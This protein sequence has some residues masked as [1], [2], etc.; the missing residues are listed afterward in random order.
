MGKKARAAVLESPGQIVIKQFDIP[1][2]GPEEGLLRIEMAGVC[3]SDTKRYY[4]SYIVRNLPLIMGHEIYGQIE[5]I[6]QIAQKKMNVKKGDHVAV[7]A[8]IRCGFC[9]SC[10]LGNYKNCTESLAYGVSIPASRPPHLW[11]AYA[12][13]MYLASGSILHKVPP[14][15]SPEAGVLIN[16]VLANGINWTRFEGGI[17]ISDTVVIQGVGPQGI[18]C[19]IAAKESGASP[20]IA[21]GLT[22]DKER[23]KLATEFGADLTIDVQKQNPVEA[24]KEITGG[25]LADLVV[26]VTG[27][28]DALNNALDLV[29]PR[30]TVVW[31]GVTGTETITPVLMD[32]IV[33]KTITLRGMYDK[34][35]KASQAA[36][37][38]IESRKYPVEKIVTH[39]FSLE[40]AEKAIQNAA[41]KITG[42]N[43]MKTVIIP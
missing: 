31:A 15:T 14:G 17:S 30:G 26:D 10:I 1:K 24:L 8:T 20:I 42:A 6:G 25:G 18:A 19:I 29:K 23:F 27:A 12:E 28:P 43:P 36:I 5:E 9:N 21:T 39:R 13:Y 34:N 2:I 4:G 22:V 3:A 11:G 38:L 37:K 35:I 40:E 41:G 33:M 32:K 16:A 7:E